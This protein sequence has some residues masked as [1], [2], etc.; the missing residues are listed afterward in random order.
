MPLGPNEVGVDKRPDCDVC[1]HVGPPPKLHA[2][3]AAYDG[4]T[5]E[6]PWAYMCE[7]HFK[8]Y[9]LGKLGIGYGQKLIYTG[10]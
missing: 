2:Q 9:G 5:K 1:K 8:K 3:P 10:D 6:G 7:Y 4:K